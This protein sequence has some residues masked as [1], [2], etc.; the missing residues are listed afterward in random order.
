[1]LIFILKNQLFYFFHNII[2]INFY[3]Y[4]L[5]HITLIILCIN[6][7]AVHSAENFM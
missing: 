6:M 2:F 4:L 5:G 1:M 3:D 7:H